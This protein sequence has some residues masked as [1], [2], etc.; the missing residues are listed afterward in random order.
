MSSREHKIHMV[1]AQIT[2]T[3]ASNQEYLREFVEEFVELWSAE[4]VEEFTAYN[5]MDRARDLH[6]AREM[7]VDHLMAE[8]T[9]DLKNGG[10][11]TRAVVEAQA[12][13]WLD[14]TLDNY[15]G[16]YAEEDCD[17]ELSRPAI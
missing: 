9:E 17:Q 16:E 6:H 7:V 12:D 4:K 13:T 1:A 14:E 8:L 2:D 10:S 11:R 5:E 3:M 15:L